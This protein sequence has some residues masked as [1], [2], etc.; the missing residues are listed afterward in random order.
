M[1]KDKILQTLEDLKK[2]ITE[3]K[4][5]DKPWPQEGDECFVLW[6]DGDVIDLIYKKNFEPRLLQGDVFRTKEVAERERDR[7]DLLAKLWRES[8]FVPD[9]NKCKQKKYYQFYNHDEE[10]WEVDCV[11]WS[12]DIFDR[13]HYATREEAQAV[14]DNNNLSVL[15]GGRG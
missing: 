9:W 5:E 4:L 10:K 14:I 8:T 2:L 11:S 12:Q 6:H 15:L 7:R 3:D 13:P 1:N